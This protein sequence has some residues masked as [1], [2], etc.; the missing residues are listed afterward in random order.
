MRNSLFILPSLLISLGCATR[1]YNASP[2]NSV[3]PGLGNPIFNC[4]GKFSNGVLGKIDVH[5]QGVILQATKG[6]KDLEKHFYAHKVVTSLSSTEATLFTCDANFPA[7]YALISGGFRI[8]F[9]PSQS[10]AFASDMPIVS[11][12]A[13]SAIVIT[14]PATTTAPTLP[15]NLIS[16]PAGHFAVKYEPNLEADAEKLKGYAVKSELAMHQTFPNSNLDKMF[17]NMNRA[18]IIVYKK[19]ND[20]ANV[21][22]M[23]VESPSV[24]QDAPFEVTLHFLAP[25]VHPSGVTT[26]AGFPMDDNYFFK[27]MAHEL[28]T[29]AMNWTAHSIGKWKYYSAPAWF[30]QGTQEYFA[31]TNT[32]QFNASKVLNANIQI[33]K[34]DPSRIQFADKISSRD[35][36][37]NYT[38]NYIDGVTLSSFLAET[39]GSQ[40]LYGVFSSQK[41]NF[42]E[43][44][45]EAFGKQSALEPKFTKWLQSK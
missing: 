30:V 38:A 1:S 3:P 29:L 25:S 22:Q 6:S 15:T 2:S 7:K 8:E 36:Q 4:T 27:V 20:K 18:D 33:V 39:F 23:M 24:I 21:G 43:A 44:F 11:P 37:S 14:N 40:A 41:T 10:F 13:E 31:V 17:K 32:T 42:D 19:P 5:Q 28:G 34:N 26:S 16:M 35:A 9:S 12:T 45:E